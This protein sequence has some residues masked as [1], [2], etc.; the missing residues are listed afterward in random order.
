MRAPCSLPGAGRIGAGGALVGRGLPATA[1]CAGVHVGVGPVGVDV[2]K[3]APA[4]AQLNH[5]LAVVVGD[6]QDGLPHLAERPQPLGAQR[7]LDHRCQGGGLVGIQHAAVHAAK[8]QCRGLRGS[9]RRHRALKN[10][11]VQDQL[12]G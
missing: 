2:N 5:R 6:L 9:P 3:L 12:G 7:R 1:G 10:I 4:P 11:A 8:H